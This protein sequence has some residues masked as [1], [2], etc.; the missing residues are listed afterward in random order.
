MP[1]QVVM[2]GVVLLGVEGYTLR[3]EDMW[4][5]CG[6]QQW[7]GMRCEASEE[8]VPL[9]CGQPVTLRTWHEAW[10]DRMNPTQREQVDYQWVGFSDADIDRDGVVTLNDYS[11]FVANP[12][13]W[14]RDGAYTPLDVH[15]V[16]ARVVNPC[17]LRTAISK[18][19]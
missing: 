8:F 15:L 1:L 6:C 12:Y 3:V 17:R 11:T 9:H 7:V 18:R 10:P 13:D 5:P 14:N 16:A 2:G 4:I 19:S